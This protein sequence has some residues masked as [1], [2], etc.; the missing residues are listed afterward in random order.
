MLKIFVT[1]IKKN[2]DCS[3]TSVRV[4]NRVRVRI[5]LGFFDS[6]HIYIYIY[7]PNKNISPLVQ[8]LCHQ[9]MGW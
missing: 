3:S 4:I 7:I 6:R 1:N 5:R 2:S 8:W 9:L